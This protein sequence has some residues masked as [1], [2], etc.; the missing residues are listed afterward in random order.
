MGL[1]S[2]GVPLGHGWTVLEGVFGWAENFARDLPIFGRIYLKGLHNLHRYRLSSSGPGL[3]LSMVR[4]GGHLNHDC[5][6]PDEVLG[7]AEIFQGVPLFLSVD[8]L[9]DHTI[10]RVRGRP[11][12]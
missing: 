7:W 4:S 12:T 9:R 5:G 6:M 2:S 1:V 10:Y 8:A 11:G 3:S